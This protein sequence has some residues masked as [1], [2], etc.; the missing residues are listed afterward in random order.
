MQLN[1]KR[2]MHFPSGKK[3]MWGWDRENMQM[4]PPTSEHV[5][6]S[7][8]LSLDTDKYSYEELFRGVYHLVSTERGKPGSH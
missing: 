8:L 6:M 1:V 5:N 2:W 3:T 4:K 7:V